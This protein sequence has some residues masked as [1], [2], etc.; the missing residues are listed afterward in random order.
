[1]NCQY[2]GQS[3]NRAPSRLREQHEAVCRDRPDV[4]VRNEGTIFLFTLHTPAVEEWVETHVQ[5]EDW[6]TFGGSSFAV[7]HRFARDLAH[8][9]QQV[10]FVVR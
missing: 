5:L 8:G 3:F 2:C 6:N 9:L 4:T 1:M 10:G 7:E